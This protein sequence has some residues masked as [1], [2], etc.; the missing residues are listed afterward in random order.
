MFYWKIHRS[1]NLYETTPEWRIFH[2]LTSEDIDDVS[3]QQ[4]SE[5][6]RNFQKFSGNVWQRSHDLR[7]S[8]GE[9]SEMF[10][11]WWEIFGKS[12]QTPSSV[13]LYITLSMRHYIYSNKINSENIWNLL[14]LSRRL[15]TCT[16]QKCMYIN[17]FPNTLTSE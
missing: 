5:I 4:S 11:K 7:T 9:S 2:I 13:C 6:F 3:L 1:Q 8:F 10:E 15:I 12:S 17:A 16:E 14:W